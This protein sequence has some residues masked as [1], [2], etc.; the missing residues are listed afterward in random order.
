MKA[1]AM[2]IQIACTLLK[3][4][5]DEL[6]LDAPFKDLLGD[7][8][9][10][11]WGVLPM[12]IEEQCGVVLSDDEVTRRTTLRGLISIVDHKRRLVAA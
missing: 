11:L 2:I 3:V 1:E 5:A 8:S 9:S 10:P 12:T 6:N 7:G 4:S